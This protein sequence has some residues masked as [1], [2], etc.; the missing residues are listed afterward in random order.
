MLHMPQQL[1]GDPIIQRTSYMLSSSFLHRQIKLYLSYFHFSLAM[2]ARNQL[3]C[4]QKY[5]YLL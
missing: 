2:A 3:S 5:Q 1:E 4:R